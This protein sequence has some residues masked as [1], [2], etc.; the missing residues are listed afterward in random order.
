MERSDDVKAD[1]EL[2]R[3]S[4]KEEASVTLSRSGDAMKIS[5]PYRYVSP[6][7]DGTYEGD[8][9]MD[10]NRRWEESPCVLFG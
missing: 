1:S 9:I 10:V 7:A 4:S 3:N 6:F 5:I 2:S 8:N